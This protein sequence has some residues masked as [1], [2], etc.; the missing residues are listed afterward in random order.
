MSEF[1]VW[2]CRSCGHIV[3]SKERPD[4]IRWTDLHVCKDWIPESE[5]KG[6]KNV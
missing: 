4:T 6:E 3:V 2:K 5:I 1:I